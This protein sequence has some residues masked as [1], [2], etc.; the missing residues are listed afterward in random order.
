MPL[1]VEESLIDSLMRRTVHQAILTVTVVHMLGRSLNQTSAR[2][3]LT[4]ADP[5]RSMVSSLYFTWGAMKTLY[6]QCLSGLRSANLRGSIEAWVSASL[7]KR[8]SGNFYFACEIDDNKPFGLAAEKHVDF[9]ENRVSMYN[10][11]STA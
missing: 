4:E 2:E 8:V 11:G 1:V 9:M 6:I 10:F 5:Y 3:C 7:P